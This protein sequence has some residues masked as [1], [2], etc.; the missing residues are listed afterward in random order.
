MKRLKTLINCCCSAE[1]KVVINQSSKISLDA[2]RLNRQ[3][4]QSVKKKR[5]RKNN[6][7]PHKK[8]K[9][10]H[11]CISKILLAIP[12]Y[13]SFIEPQED[14]FK[15]LFQSKDLNLLVAQ[16]AKL[17][18]REAKTDV[19][20]FLEINSKL[21]GKTRTLKKTSTDNRGDVCRLALKENEVIQKRKMFCVMKFS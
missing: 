16:D 21:H 10:G 15:R 6:R 11:S 4:T 1:T 5:R 2:S 12:F 17:Q 9:R 14:R 18:K 13:K 8:K 20:M 3:N 7:K 19:G